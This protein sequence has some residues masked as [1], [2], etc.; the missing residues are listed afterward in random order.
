MKAR[1]WRGRTALLPLAAVAGCLSPAAP[2]P[3]SYFKP[4]L[5]RAAAPDQATQG[6]ELHFGRVTAAPYLDQRMA[7]RVSATEYAFDEL[8]RWV[9]APAELVADAL[10]EALF[11]GGVAREG[12]S[13]TPSLSVHLTAFELD[14]AAPET[15]RVEAVATLRPKAGAAVVRSFAHARKVTAGSAEARAEAIGAATAELAQA[16]AEFVAG[17][18]R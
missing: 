18:Q 16:V 3:V 2:P 5:S 12:T 7:Y 17:A 14:L 9:A 1:A 10:T 4:P 15:A 8:N 11:V 13:P 6:P